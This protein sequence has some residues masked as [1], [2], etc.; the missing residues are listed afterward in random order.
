MDRNS[1]KQGE[2]SVDDTSAWCRTLELSTKCARRENMMDGELGR[3]LPLVLRQRACVP[4]G[5]GRTPPR[6]YNTEHNRRAGRERFL[7]LHSHSPPPPTPQPH[8]TLLRPF[9]QLYRHVSANP[10]TQA[11]CAPLPTRYLCPPLHKPPKW[12]PTFRN[13]DASHRLDTLGCRLSHV[14]GNFFEKEAPS[15]L[16]PLPAEV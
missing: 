1:P 15:H 12:I 9:S 10:C 13:E 5:L 7:S 2:R 6:T 4:T 3:F 11:T 8:P 14:V 16:L